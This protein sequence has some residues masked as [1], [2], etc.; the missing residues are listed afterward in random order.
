[1]DITGRGCHRQRGAAD[2]S[3]CV[4]LFIKHTPNSLQTDSI[5]GCLPNKRRLNAIFDRETIL[6]QSER[7][8]KDEAATSSFPLPFSLVEEKKKIATEESITGYQS[9][10]DAA[11]KS[12]LAALFGSRGWCQ[13]LLPVWPGTLGRGAG[14]FGYSKVHVKDTHAHV[15]NAQKLLR[16]RELRPH[17]T[18]EPFNMM[19]YCT[20]VSS[21]GDRGLGDVD[22]RSARRWGASVGGGASQPA[23]SCHSGPAERHPGRPPIYARAT[24]GFLCG[25]K[26]HTKRGRRAQGRNASPGERN[27]LTLA[28]KAAI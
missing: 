11:R 6:K 27:K 8:L 13:R 21:A 12:E 1:M 19:L 3:D 20:Y 25:G 14:V 5:S 18:D 23:A 9:N 28:D 22:C 7:D 10:G 17:I 26:T 16:H 4:A 2:G 24:N 15:H